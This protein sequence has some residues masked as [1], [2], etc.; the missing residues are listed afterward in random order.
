MKP[1]VVPTRDGIDI[2]C[3]QGTQAVKALFEQ[4]AVLIRALEARIQALEDQLAKN[5]RNRSKP[6]S[7][8]GLKKPKPRSRR[9][10]SG[11]PSG[12]QKGHVGYRLEPVAKPQHTEVHP[13]LACQR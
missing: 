4:Q 10:R 2:A 7:S 11:K 6:P 1:S 3:E 8:D 5:S 9:E 13:V 12:G